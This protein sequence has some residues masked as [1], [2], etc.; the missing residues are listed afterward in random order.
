MAEES[1]AVLIATLFVRW[2]G[3]YNVLK[4]IQLVGN[5]LKEAVDHN[6]HL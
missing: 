1:R 4:P 3:I 5:D 6:R 2:L